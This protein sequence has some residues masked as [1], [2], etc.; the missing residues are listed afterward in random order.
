MNQRWEYCL[1]ACT[2]MSGLDEDGVR[3]AYQLVKPDLVQRLE[4]HSG[5]RSPFVAIGGLLNELGDE[6]WELVA[7]DT[8]TNRGVFKRLKK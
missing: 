1:L 5:D 2:P 6:G 3:I 7:Y 4:L 8:T